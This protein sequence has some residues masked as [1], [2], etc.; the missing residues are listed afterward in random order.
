MQGQV[1]GQVGEI[2]PKVAKNFSLSG[3]V[4]FFCIELEKIENALYSKIQ[5]K[6]VSPYQENNFDLSF[7]V[8]KN[9]LGKDIITAIEKSDTLIQKVELFDIYES[10]DK[11]P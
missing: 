8:H 6:E 2:H 1:V 7:V 4:G 11:L 10:E 3:R 5:T 9:T